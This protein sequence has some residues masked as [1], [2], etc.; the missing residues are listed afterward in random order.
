M[1]SNEMGSSFL[2]L[3][4]V[5]VDG[6]FILRHIPHTFVIK[7]LSTYTYSKRMRGNMEC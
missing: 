3:L 7:A 6:K 1:T 4:N 2:V 5:L